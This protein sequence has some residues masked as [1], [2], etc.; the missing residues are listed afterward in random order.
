MGIF[1][2]LAKYH[3]WFQIFP[4]NLWYCTYYNITKLWCHS[5]KISTMIL[6]ICIIKVGKTS[7]ICNHDITNWDC[8]ITK[9]WRNIWNNIWCALCTALYDIIGC[10]IWIHLW[11]W[12]YDLIIEIIFDVHCALCTVHCTLWYHRLHHL[13][14]F[15]MLVIWSHYVLLWY[16]CYVIMVG[17]NYFISLNCDI[18]YWSQWSICNHTKMFWNHSWKIIKS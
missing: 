7:Q 1:D 16:Y 6:C 10:I 5:S 17:G 4:R 2:N 3:V 12:L 14:S 15:V 11:F 18:T 9:L 13:H 8:E